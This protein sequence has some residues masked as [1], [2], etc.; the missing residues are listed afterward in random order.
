MLSK[1]YLRM[2]P[3]ICVMISNLFINLPVA[4]LSASLKFFRSLGFDFNDQFSD[5]TAACMI[6]SHNMCVMLL[7]HEKF[8]LFT[9]KEVAD[10]KTTTEVLL[11]M[12]VDQKGKVDA[13]V[14]KAIAAGGEEPRPPQDHGF[15]YGRSFSDLDGHIWEVLWMQA[16]QNN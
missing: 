10:S 1:A 11:A 16:P 5:D 4:D 7:T 8:K 13:M 15:M 3:N 14:N 6:L 12:S 9:P 2:L